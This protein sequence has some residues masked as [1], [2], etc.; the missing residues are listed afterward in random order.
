MILKR[1]T[2]PAFHRYGKVMEGYDFTELLKKLEEVS[3]CPEGRTVYVA[4]DAAL[5][6]LPVF[7]ELK[8]KAYG[9]MPIQIGYCNGENYK[10]NCL[11][12]HRD[13]EIN[14][15]VNDAILILGRMEDITDG[16]LDTSKA[17]AFLLP[18]GMGAEVYATSLHYAPACAPGENGFRV[19]VVLPRGTNTEMPEFVPGCLEDQWMTA[20]NKW[21][22]AHPEAKEAA[23]GAY[24]GLTGKNLD[25]REDLE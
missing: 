12:Y 23:K 6:A 2:D 11:E 25:V 17:E 7:E 24:V 14:V 5:E 18:A 3:P 10:L 9:G 16:K 19:I 22:L 20:R 1:V 21:L 15:A 8:N 13:S 4:S